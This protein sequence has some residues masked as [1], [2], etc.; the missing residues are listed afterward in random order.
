ME[1]VSKVG[2]CPGLLGNIDG[3]TNQ[4]LIYVLFERQIQPLRQVALLE[5]KMMDPLWHATKKPH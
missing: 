1:G 2:F 3:I 4:K 5:S